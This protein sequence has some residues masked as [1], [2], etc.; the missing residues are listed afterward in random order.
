VSSGGLVSHQK[1]PLEPNYQVPFAERIKNEVGILTGAVGLIT[2][3][4]QAE[5]IVN[6][7]K[8]ILFCLLENHYAIR[9]WV[10]ILPKP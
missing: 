3:A 5:S 7:G 10:Y 6:S 1:I 9:I 8:Q 4:S 2:E